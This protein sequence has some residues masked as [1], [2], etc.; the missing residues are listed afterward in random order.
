[1]TRT[2]LRKPPRAGPRL[3][4]RRASSRPCTYGRIC[5]RPPRPRSVSPTSTTPSAA[6][7]RSSLTSR[8]RSRAPGRGRMTW[9]SLCGCAPPPPRRALIRRRH[10]A[11]SRRSQSTQVRS[12]SSRAMR[13]CTPQA[14]LVLTAPS[15]H[16]P[17]RTSPRCCASTS[18][19]W[20]RSSGGCSLS[21]RPRSATRIV[22]NTGL[23]PRTS[24]QGPRQ[25]LLLTRVSLASDSAR[26]PLPA[27]LRGRSELCRSGGGGEGGGGQ[28]ATPPPPRIYMLHLHR[29]HLVYISHVHLRSASSS[30][31]RCCACYYLL[32][33]IYYLLL[34]R[35]ASSSTSRCCACSA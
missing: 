10:Q 35:S 22:S 24:R 32:L 15:I 12:A 31:S 14:L 18:V 33:T 27:A 28:G 21:C 16:H 7:R 6:R 3:H 2:P 1:M 20:H 30:T 11:R 29:S 17:P 8:R 19:T 9:V 13:G 4:R 34:T 25:V 23:E 26:L 5:R